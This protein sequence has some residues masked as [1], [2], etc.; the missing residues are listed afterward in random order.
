[1]L[2]S[3]D[4]NFS[5]VGDIEENPFRTSSRYYNNLD[6]IRDLDEHW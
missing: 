3:T 1:M 4:L 6:Y 2:R 5:G